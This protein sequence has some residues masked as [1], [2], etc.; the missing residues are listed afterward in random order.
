MVDQYARE[1]WGEICADGAM[2]EEAGLEVM[3][4]D[5]VDTATKRSCWDEKTGLVSRGLVISRHGRSA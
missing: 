2:V 4:G 1:S 5:D 3:L